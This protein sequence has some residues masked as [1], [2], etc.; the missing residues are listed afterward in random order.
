MATA[1][2]RAALAPAK[3]CSHVTARALSTN[4]PATTGSKQLEDIYAAAT[5]QESTS[6]VQRMKNGECFHTLKSCPAEL[7]A[8]AGT[9]IL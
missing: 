5:P 9:H 4:V 8:V 1:L 6:F 7:G 2:V 3:A